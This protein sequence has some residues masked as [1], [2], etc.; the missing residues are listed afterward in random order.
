MFWFDRNN[1][2]ATFVD[3]RREVVEIGSGRSLTIDPDVVADFRELPFED[4]SFHL[5]VFD[6]PHLTSV[7]Q[8]SWLA[9]KYGKLLST[10]QDD[11][12]EGFAEC[13]RVLRPYGTLVFKWND[14]DIPI[15]KVLRLS[16]SPP[17]FGSRSVRDGGTKWFCFMKEPSP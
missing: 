12:T 1:P 13:F 10:W 8:K 6:P 2:L 7:G 15:S 9:K 16:P 5:V 4:N 14:H 11:L 3:S 17:L